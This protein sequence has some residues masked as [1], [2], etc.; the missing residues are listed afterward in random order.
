MGDDFPVQRCVNLDQ[1]LEA[2]REG[3]WGYTIARGDI[4][5][6]AAQGFDTVRLP[7]R[8]HA[9]WDDGLD[10]AILARVDEVIGWAMEDGLQVILDLH[11]FE[12]LMDDPSTYGPTF[13]AIWTVLSDHYA[14]YDDALI[15]E[16]LNEPSK[17]LD[18]AGAVT[19]FEAVWPD[20]RADHPD[21]WIVIEGGWWSHHNQLPDLPLFDART[22]LSFHYYGPWEFTHQQA[23][24]LDNP[25][26]PASWGSRADWNTLR[27]DFADAAG[28]DAPLFLGEFGVTEQTAPDERAEW[29]GA[30]RETAETH[31]IGWC[32]WGFAGGFKLFDPATQD[33]VPG[34]SPALLG[35]P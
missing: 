8:F 30:V 21:R 28:R 27:R 22:A 5:W 13:Q 25:P 29:I 31:G 2:P 20:I 3:D 18:T 26:P 17:E 1:A 34:M 10:P 7:V 15:F 35:Q 24:W 23:T 19:L 9:Y 16:L 32:H 6:I 4:A 33:W 12:P 14:G 11:H